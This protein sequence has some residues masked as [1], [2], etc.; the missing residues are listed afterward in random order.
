V[1]AQGLAE[2]ESEEW[3]IV[4]D[5]MEFTVEN[6]QIQ[7]GMVWGDSIRPR[8]MS[9]AYTIVADSLAVDTPDQIL[10]EMRAYG[11]AHATSRGDS[12]DEEPDWMAGDTV[13]ARFDTTAAGVRTLVELAARGNAQA[14]YKIFDEE[15]PEGPPAFNY[16]RGT[17]IIARFTDEAV[18]RVDVV[19]P[20]DGVYLEPQRIPPP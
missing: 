20:A 2:A 7:A 10:T 9:T 19:G 14:F 18:N 13:V 5:T 3:R 11:G 12:I 16:S 4:G 15:D 17:H 6:D 1:Q 8:A